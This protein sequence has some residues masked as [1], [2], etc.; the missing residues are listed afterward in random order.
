MKVLN[1]IVL[2]LLI[3]GALNWLLIGLFEF[4]LVSFIFGELSFLSRLIYVLV[5][6]CGVWAIAFYSKISD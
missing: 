4:N 5:G 6:I 1:Y 2:T 3:I